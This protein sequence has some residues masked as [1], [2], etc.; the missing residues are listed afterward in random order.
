MIDPHPD[1][2]PKTTRFLDAGIA[3]SRLTQQYADRRKAGEVIP[4]SDWLTLF[5]AKEELDE[6]HQEAAAAWQSEEAIA[7]VDAEAVASIMTT[8]AEHDAIFQAIRRKR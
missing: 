5:V 1:I 7:E 3:F 6:A 8:T 2:W 4:D